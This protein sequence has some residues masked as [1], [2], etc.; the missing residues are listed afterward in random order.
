[1]TM[2]GRSKAKL[3][4]TRDVRRFLLENEEIKTLILGKIYPLFAPENTNGDFILYMRDGHSTD[5]TQMGPLSQ[6]CRVFINVISDDY[7]RG[8]DI[9]ELI[10]STLEGDHSNGLRMHLKD[11]T[12][13]TTDKKYIQV[14]LFEISNS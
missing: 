7:D 4:V 9:A 2:F 14:L 1:M 13:D 12:E 6:A 3:K 5:Y 8:L 11:S 10:L